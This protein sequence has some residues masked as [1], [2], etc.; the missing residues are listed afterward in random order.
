MSTRETC[1]KQNDKNRIYKNAHIRIAKYVHS[2]YLAQL[3]TWTSRIFYK[4]QSKKTV[5]YQKN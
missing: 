5:H 2:I 4:K 1:G 3:N